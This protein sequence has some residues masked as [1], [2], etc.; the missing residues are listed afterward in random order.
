MLAKSPILILSRAEGFHGAD[1][2]FYTTQ[3]RSLPPISA[4]R[5]WSH[6]TFPE[7]GTVVVWG[8]RA[9]RSGPE[10]VCGS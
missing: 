5:A 1:T 10:Q 7:E 3:A 8:C 6:L 2:L 4:P 9:I